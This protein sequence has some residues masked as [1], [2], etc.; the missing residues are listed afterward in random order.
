MSKN[1]LKNI[2]QDILLPA[3]ITI[4][5]KQPW[6]I[7]VKNEALYG[8]IL[9]EGSLG[10]GES[11]MDGWWDCENLDG[12]FSRLIPTQPEDKIRKNWKLLLRAIATVMID[13]G[14]KSRAFQVGECHYD[15][16]NELYVR[17][18]DKRM[19]YSC[20]YWK[21]ANNLHEA[22]EA[23]LELICRK[24]AI[25]PGDR[26]LDIGCGWGGFTKYAAENY[27][28]KVVGITVSREQEKY[29]RLMC[30]GLPVEIRH[31]DYRDVDERFDHIVSVGMFE[32]VGLRHYRNYMEVVHRCLKDDGLFLLHT[33]GSNRSVRVQDAWNEKYIF[34]NSL[35]PSLKQISDAVENLFVIEDLHNFGADYNKTL[36]CWFDNFE[37]SWS[38]LKGKY[39]ERFYRMWKYYLLIFAA[40][41]RSRYLQVWQLVLSKYGVPGG[42][43]PIR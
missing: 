43:R 16:G 30:A 2:V 8:R 31:Q 12:F 24:L 14:C 32:H 29:A 25:R 23:K 37:R 11:Y 39:G 7:Q 6:D 15:I 27:G 9:R 10:L 41:F 34:P 26:I 5:G 40:A 20:G 3:G 22:Q 38:D 36:L 13:K 1:T 19:V 17:M 33:M 18:L 21:Q 42:Y 28:V 4:N 35:V